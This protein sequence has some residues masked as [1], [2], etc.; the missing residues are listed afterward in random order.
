MTEI[1]WTQFTNELDALYQPPFRAVATH[2]QVMQVLREVGGL[3]G[4]TTTG[5]LTAAT[6]AAWIRAHPGRG[7]ARTASNLRVLAVACCY[8]LKAGYVDRSPFAFRGPACWV[9]PD[10]G[11]ASVR[12]P[13]HKSAAEIA[14]VL[15]LVDSEAAGGTW[16]AG[17]LQ[18]LVYTYAFTGLRRAEALHLEHNDIDL[19]RRVLTV[20]PKPTWRPKTL[21]SSARLPIAA[22]L[23][24]VLALWMP[25]TGCRWVFPGARLRGPWAGGPPG[26]TPLD[27]VRAAG[28]RAGVEN[29]TILAFRKTLGT[30]A[31]SWGF[32]Q[33]ELKAL[34]R[35]TSIHT[36]TWY[37][38]DDVEV[39]RPAADRITFPRAATP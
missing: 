3:P 39:L 23:A 11:P 34:L 19:V 15:E 36:Q 27:Q 9:R 1:P 22:P 31:K 4:V 33:L 12:K 28:E 18:A 24:A 20:R 8:A 10:A 37:D 35:H 5:D 7:P 38:E 13:A 25:R 6:V 32:S 26:A 14:R 16:A 17:R 29:L 30:L 21:A 2:R